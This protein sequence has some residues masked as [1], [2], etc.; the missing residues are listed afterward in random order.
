MVL[1]G[2]AAAVA[3]AMALQKTGAIRTAHHAS[4]VHPGE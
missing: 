2:L 3:F 4:V 1:N